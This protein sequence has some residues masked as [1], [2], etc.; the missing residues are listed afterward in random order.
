MQSWRRLLA[1]EIHSIKPLRLKIVKVQ[2]N[3]TVDALASRMAPTDHPADRFR[4]LNGL[5]SG[6]RPKPG[7]LVKLIV[8]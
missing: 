7:D 5:E 1:D 6:E 2:P 4:I 8:E 3:D